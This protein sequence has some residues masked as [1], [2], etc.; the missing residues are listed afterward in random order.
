MIDTHAH[1]LKEYYGDSLE[2]KMN[3]CNESLEKVINSSFDI[4]TKKSH[5]PLL[6]LWDFYMNS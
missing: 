6:E 3:E 5:S 2:T 1:L 4:N